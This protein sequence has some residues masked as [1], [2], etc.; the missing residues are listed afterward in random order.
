MT[1]RRE[2]AAYFAIVLRDPKAEPSEIMRALAWI[3]GNS[4]NRV[5]FDEAENFLTTCDEM[6]GDEELRVQLLRRSALR[7]FRFPASWHSGLAAAASAVLVVMLGASVMLVDRNFQR[8]DRDQMSAQTRY[9]SA[10][11]EIRKV[12]LPDGSSMTLAGATAVSVRYS[13]AERRIVLTDGQA[14]F[15]VAHDRAHPF[16]VETGQGSAIAVGTAFD[17]HKDLRGATVTV[18]DGVVDV[19]AQGANLQSRLRLNRS[20]QASYAQNGSISSPEN[21][22][23]RLATAWRRGALYP[24]NQPLA[25]VI[26]DLNR[27]SAK[28][29]TLDQSDT[30]MRPVTGTI[31]TDAIAEW[32]HG[33]GRL[34]DLEVIETNHQIELRPAVHRS[35]QF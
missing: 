29:I 33:L 27:Y 20:M 28:P 6:A 30:G 17:V 35:E 32:L 1:E 12:R 13:G 24:R 18:L 16:V 8:G 2:L 14:Y 26:A 3:D 4:D 9:T 5:S 19:V 25:A 22:D 11:G 21:V 34:A 31:R 10:I 23:P 7:R 15:E